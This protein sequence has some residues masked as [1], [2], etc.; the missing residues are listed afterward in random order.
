MS[1][2]NNLHN[3]SK[4]HKVFIYT[5]SVLLSLTLFWSPNSNNNLGRCQK[6]HFTWTTR[7]IADHKYFN[8]SNFV[9]RSSTSE[10]SFKVVTLSSPTLLTVATREVEVNFW[11]GL[12]EQ[13]KQYSKALKLQSISVEKTAYDNGDTLVCL[14]Y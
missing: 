7:S 4:L 2:H 5:F 11:N 8:T 14:P 9:Q 12:V 3:K 1:I 10:Q 6:F 13:K